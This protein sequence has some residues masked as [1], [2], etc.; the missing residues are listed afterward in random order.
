MTR[1]DLKYRVT[2]NS[3]T[4]R[5]RLQL[6]AAEYLERMGARMRSRREELRMTRGDVARAMP[7]RTN[8]NAIYRWEKGQHRPE[9]DA[10]EALARVLQVSGAG[11]FFAE[12]TKKADTPSPFPEPAVEGELAEILEAIRAQ[13]TEQTRVLD[14][15]KAHAANVETMLVEQREL[16]AETD[17]VAEAIRRLGHEIVQGPR[18]ETPDRPPVPGRRGGAAKKRAAASRTP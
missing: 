6:V 8:E 16:K 7:G 18:E 2:G 10:L 5:L 11:W 17:E 13:L 14:E 12:D 3:S 1:Q 4:S 15:I 9:D